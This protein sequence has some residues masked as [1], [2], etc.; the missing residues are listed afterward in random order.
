MSPTDPKPETSTEEERKRRVRFLGRLRRRLLAGTAIVVGIALIYGVENLRGWRAWSQERDRLQSAGRKV[1]LEELIPPPVPDDRN[2]AMIPMLRPL[3]DFDLTASA[4]NVWRDPEGG[5][6]AHEVMSFD[7]VHGGSVSQQGGTADSS[8]ARMTDLSAWQRYFRTPGK[9]SKAWSAAEFAQR[10]GVASSPPAPAE[11][12]APVVPG[13]PLPAE[14]GAPEA[15]VLAALAVFEPEFRAIHEGLMLPESRFPLRYE[16]GYRTLLPHLA[17]LSRLTLGFTLRASARLAAGD[18]EGAFADTLD[19]F[20]LGESLASEPFQLSQWTRTTALNRAMGMLWEGQVRHA[21]T[22][23]H[24]AAFQSRLS[25]IETTSAMRLS[26]GMERTLA[27]QWVERVAGSFAERRRLVGLSGDL[28]GS[29]LDL[30]DDPSLVPALLFAPR[31][32]LYANAAATAQAFAELEST[33]AT[34]LPGLRERWRPLAGRNS[35]RLLFH[36][37]YF[38]GEHGSKQAENLVRALACDHRIRLA[39]TACALE[40]YRLRHRD[41]PD[42]LE[43]LVPDLLAALPQDEVAGRPLRYQREANG[44][45][46]LWAVGDDGRD[47]GGLLSHRQEDSGRAVAV[48]WVWRWPES[49]SPTRP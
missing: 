46:R 22:E 23:S 39:M 38:S 42:A 6:R 30:Q 31:G 28:F 24:L 34:E 29:F 27:W 48:D 1:T 44:T 13:Y 14:P 5:R 20:G 33:P 26:F 7:K 43:A 9:G 2:F 3:F 15:D 17:V 12:S 47:E 32:W 25:A 49:G 10:Y 21:W 40:R 18:A 11:V 35:V 8:R 45:F 37:R 36:R 4:T 19:A 16:D 41:Y